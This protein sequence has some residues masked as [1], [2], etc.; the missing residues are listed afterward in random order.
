WRPGPKHVSVDRARPAAGRLGRR[1]CEQAEVDGAGAERDGA[2]AA[3]AD[4][5]DECVGVEVV[6]GGD[7]AVGELADRAGSRDRAGEQDRRQRVVDE[8]GGADLAVLAGGPPRAEREPG[9]LA[10]GA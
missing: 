2:A 7:P 10:P 5:W 6:R 4:R 9:P 8:R 1:R 3:A